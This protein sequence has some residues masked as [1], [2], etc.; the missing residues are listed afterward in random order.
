[1]KKLLSILLISA[2]PLACYS[3]QSQLVTLSDCYRDA[4]LAS[5]VANESQALE[6]LSLL[7]DK[8]I[9]SGWYPSLE[10]GATLLYNT[11]VVDLSSA[12]SSLP[13]PIPPGAIGGMPKDQ[14]RFTIDINQVIYDGGAI[15]SSRDAEMA[16]LNYKRQSVS[17]ELY[18]IK[19]QVNNTFFVL[20]LLQKQKALLVSYRETLVDRIKAVGSAVENGMLLPTD[21]DILRS[22]KVKVDQQIAET[23]IRLA[24]LFGVL[25]DITNKDYGNE[26]E[27]SI[28]AVEELPSGINGR[29]ELELFDLKAIQLDARRDLLRSSRKPK[30]FGF[31]T[32]G[33]GSPPGNDFFT[34]SFGT[35]A[36]VGA[37]IKWT[38]TD[39]N[40]AKRDEQMIDLN[41]MIISSKK[42]DLEGN[43]SRALR[44]KKS[45]IDSYISMLESDEELISIRRSVTEATELKLQ[46]GVITATDY[47]AE[48][49]AEKQAMLNRELHAVSLSKAKIEYMYISGKEIE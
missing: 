39:W 45:E 11:N 28:P 42:D 6:Q 18:K 17:V 8:N 31:A 2:G 37:G 25:S 47:L 32:L 29:P 38:I 5:P 15:R 36:V 33:Y 4:I 22:E 34:D 9:L 49:N 20:I 13:V 41:K 46:N 7:K 16:S 35:Y 30:A 40:R 43:L 3:Q 21:Y 23:E 24:G 27:L 14:Y 44:L 48:L 10:A 1:M 26:T 19:E 12:L